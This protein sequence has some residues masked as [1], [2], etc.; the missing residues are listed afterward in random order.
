M[1]NIILQ[2]ITFLI[3]FLFATLFLFTLPGFGFIKFLRIKLPGYL[4]KYMLSTAL[5]LTS[6]TLASYLL[7]LIH[8][9]DLIWIFISF[10]F[11][12]AAKN[13]YHLPLLMTKIK[14]GFFSLFTL[15]LIIGSLGLV[16]INAPSGL[17]YDRGVL[18][19]SAHGHDGI[20]HVALIEQMS[21]ENFAFTNP[22]Y[23]G[24]KLQNY[25][26]FIDLLMSEISRILYFSPM[27][28]YFRFMPA[29]L[30]IL[31]GLASFS[32]VRR[33]S[34]STISGFWSMVF[35][36]FLGNF[37]F[38]VTFL[39]NGNL[40]GESVFWIPQL[41]SV[42]GNPPQ[43]TAVMI[44]AALAYC[45]LAFLRDKERE[46]LLPIVILGSTL[47]EFKV[48]AGVVLLGALFLVGVYELFLKRNLW[49][50]SLFVATLIP[51]GL[52]SLP[53]AKGASDYLIFEPWWFIRTMVVASDKLN[54][55]DLELKRQTYLYEH[56]I[57]RVIQLELTA[58]SIYV[59]GNLGVRLIGL[60]QGIK[61]LLQKKLFRDSFD[62]FFLAITLLS[63]GIPM[64]F[65]QK[66]VA[67]NIIQTSQYALLFLSF[68][69]AYALGEVFTKV[70]KK[71]L[72]VV[73]STVVILLGI[74]TQIGL[75]W[76]FYAHP[77]NAIIQNSQ[78][79]ALTF[80]KNKSSDADI[81]LTGFYDKYKREQYGSLPLPINAWSDTGY[82]SAETGRKTLITDQEQLQI[83]N[84]DVDRLFDE[85]KEIFASKDPKMVNNFLQKYKVN[86]IYLENREEFA[87][88]TA[89][90]NIEKIYNK[91]GIRIY[92][93]K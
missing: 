16:L 93:V 51:A 58:F 73:L 82:V 80:L 40:N 38:I 46:H 72:L 89:K 59:V 15:I 74:P 60:M 67:Y 10:G 91:E 61:M 70:K 76:G 25:H 28:L 17:K 27:D 71:A 30:S 35:V 52:I 92:K 90:L 62:L 24:Q 23:A 45:I 29:L 14:R 65:L 3:L 9:R 12:I 31:L 53:N 48:Y 66:G 50:V 26:F 22:E 6:F 8:A 83:M 39:R 13:I 88:D 77:P 55:L 85:R 5:G 47:V 78:I 49:P 81:I 56:N 75:L 44:M 33:W 42:Q 21:K 69:S 87:I 57:K 64:L 54:W 43:A 37:G 68:L 18:F 32:F 63:F 2:Q 4:D 20:W 19:W 41:F 79:E 84:Y 86:F 1:S 34:G 36:Y 11:F 7:S